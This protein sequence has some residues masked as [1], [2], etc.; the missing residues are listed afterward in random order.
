MKVLQC[1]EKLSGLKV[2]LGM[3]CLYGIGVSEASISSLAEALGCKAGKFS[4]KYFGLSIGSRMNKLKDWAPYVDK[5]NN[6]LG[7]WR[8]KNVVFWQST[9][10]HKFG[11]SSLPLYAF[12]LFRAPAG[13]IKHL[14]DPRG[15]T[16]DEMLLLEELIRPFR[17]SYS[18][19]DNW[20]YKLNANGLFSTKSLA[21]KINENLLSSTASGS[22]TDRNI[23]VPKKIGVFI[24][25]EKMKR[26][27][28]REELDKRGIDLN[29]LVC[30]MCN[31][32]IESVEHILCS[33]PFTI[34]VWYRVRQWWE[35][36]NQH[37]SRVN[38]LFRGNHS[39]SSITSTCKVWQAVEW[40]YGYSLWK[41]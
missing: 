1:F 23:L 2:N 19:K 37:Y 40:V 9:Y 11:P 26:L 38:D 41:F 14:K 3:S 30:L 25:Q 6:M 15:R 17:F 13:V 12:S 28:V 27:P 39:T 31:T 10:I 18:S 7:E 8:A 35:L 29:T 16:A 34:D 36:P 20:I 32:D 33:C 5:I 4:M 22:Q 21:E 24:W